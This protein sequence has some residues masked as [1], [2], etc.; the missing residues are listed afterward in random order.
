MMGFRSGGEQQEI[1]NV[2]LGL[3]IYSHDV[4]CLSYLTVG[5]L[6]TII[7]AENKTLRDQ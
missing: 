4:V 2:G 7:P 3:Q 1:I 6:E 5:F